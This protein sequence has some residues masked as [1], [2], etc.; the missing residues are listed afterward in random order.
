MREFTRRREGARLKNVPMLIRGIEAS[1]TLGAQDG[2]VAPKPLCEQGLREVTQL[3]TEKPE[4]T[5]FAAPLRR[6]AHD[7]AGGR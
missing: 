6:T 4:D 5:P 2:R 3:A 1:M 7:A